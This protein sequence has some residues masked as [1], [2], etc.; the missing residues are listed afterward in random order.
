MSLY[1]VR[2]QECAGVKSQQVQRL[3]TT[4]GELVIIL[5]TRHSS[6]FVAFL[7]PP[8]SPH[9]ILKSSGLRIGEKTERNAFHTRAGTKVT[10]R[11]KRKVID[12]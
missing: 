5:Q 2:S 11:V 10:H 8:L 12:D 1:L 7:Q 9:S 4:G 6:S 3:N